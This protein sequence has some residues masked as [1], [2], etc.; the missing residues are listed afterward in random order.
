MQ[1]LDFVKNLEIIVNEL[2]SE[3]ISNKFKE[4]FNSPSGYG[5]SQINAPIFTSKSNFDRLKND[6]KYREIL[7]SLDA[8][9]IYSPQNL[10]NLTII[11]QNTG[12]L[13]ILGNPIS[14][15]FFNFHNSL[16]NTL[17][18]TKEVLLNDTLEKSNENN[19]EEGILLFQIVIEEEGLSTEKYIKIFTALQELISVISKIESEEQFES[20]IILL[21]SGS[22]TNLGIKTG[23]ETAKSL[24]LIFKEFWDFCINHKHYKAKLENVSLLESLSVREEIKNKVEAGVITEDEGKEYMHLVKTRTDALIGLKVLPKVIVTETNHVDNQKLIAG[25]EGTKF[26]T[27]GE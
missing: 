4:G 19:L 17:K 12:A 11:L 8:D 6:D 5:Y 3:E 26:L 9:D 1:K 21:D 24:F 20:E 16:I 25:F 14:S 22:D 27:A 15:K 23:I 2:Q 13:Q 18:I 10:S 7:N